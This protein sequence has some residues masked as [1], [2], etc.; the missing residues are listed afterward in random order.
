MCFQGRLQ[1]RGGSE[2]G[3]AS[4]ERLDMKDCLVVSGEG[5]DDGVKR[6]KAA[7]QISFTCIRDCEEGQKSQDA[8]EQ[9]DIQPTGD[10]SQYMRL[11]YDHLQCC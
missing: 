8:I 1:G 4:Q 11:C 2:E 5:D 10:H 9:V 7:R 3:G 6:T